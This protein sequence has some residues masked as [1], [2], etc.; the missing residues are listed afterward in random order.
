MQQKMF[1]FNSAFETPYKD[2]TSEFETIF[3][4]WTCVKKIQEVF[5]NEPVQNDEE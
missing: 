1:F 5:E 4:N 3:E 2:P